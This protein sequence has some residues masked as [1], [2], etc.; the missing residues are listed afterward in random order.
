M[1]KILQRAAQAKKDSEEEAALVV[2]KKSKKAASLVKK[3]AHE[4]SNVIYLGHI[5]HG[6]YE[7]EMRVFFKQFGEVKKI[8]L[9]KS[10]KSGASKG[11]AFVEFDSE[12]TAEVVASAVN[13][14]FLQEKQLVCHTIAKDKI[15]DGMFRFPKKRKTEEEVEKE[16]ADAPVVDNIYRNRLRAK[17]FCDAQMSKK[18]KLKSLGIEY[19]IPL[20]IADE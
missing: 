13:G 17:K 19:D 6:F 14:Y 20:P 8:K 7:K 4:S 9:F 11:Y 15:H 16:D 18:E 2:S 12:D 5:P 3:V 1:S 10:E